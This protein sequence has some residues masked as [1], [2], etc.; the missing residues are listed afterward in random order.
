MFCRFLFIKV[1]LFLSKDSVF[2][3]KTTTAILFFLFKSS[4]HNT[5]YKINV[6]SAFLH[7]QVS[8][9]RYQ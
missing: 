8:S 3:L 4:K 5:K 1:F 6:L 2:C 9:Q 7:T